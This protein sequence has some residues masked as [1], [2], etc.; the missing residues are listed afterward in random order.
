MLKNLIKVL[1]FTDH[2][3]DLMY[4]KVQSATRLKPDE[5][6]GVIV[7]LLLVLMYCLTII[8]VIL[9]D[10]DHNNESDFK[11]CHQTISLIA[12]PTILLCMLDS[13]FN[14]AIMKKNENARKINLASK[15]IACTLLVIVIQIS[16]IVIHK[17]LI[18]PQEVNR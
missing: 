18:K 17:K 15:L 7:W 8:F 12:W 5:A 6:Q 1:E 4:K 2:H 10:V 11:K 13:N 3:I 9:E 16:T 14:E